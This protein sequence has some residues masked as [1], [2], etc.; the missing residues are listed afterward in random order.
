MVWLTFL[1]RFINAINAG[2]SPAQIAGGFTLG[3]MIGLVPGWPLQDV[4][5]LLVTLIVNVNLGM[6]LAGA[7]VAVFVGWL[8]DPFFDTFGA[9]LL[10]D[11]EFLQ[12]LW[13]FMYNSPLLSLTRF[14]NTVVMGSTV[15]ALLLA[16]PM[17]WTVRYIVFRY[18]EVILAR[19]RE[20]RLVRFLQGSR[21]YRWYK[22]VRELGSV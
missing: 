1:G 7:F 3:F 16:L 19:I 13:I 12:G 10:L 8:F 5:L 9:G 17:F 6:A 20:W 18:R 22:R 4:V 2:A 15:T 11:V 21:A 14:N